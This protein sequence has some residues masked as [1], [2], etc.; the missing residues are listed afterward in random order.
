MTVVCITDTDAIE[1]LFVSKQDVTGEYVT[2]QLL[3]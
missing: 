3:P 2:R 1:L